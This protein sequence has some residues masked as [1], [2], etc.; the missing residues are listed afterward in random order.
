MGRDHQVGR[1]ELRAPLAAAVLGGVISSTA[2]TL[3]LIPVVYS[4]LESVPGLVGRIMRFT[5]LAALRSQRS[6]PAAGDSS[7][8][9]GG[10]S[11]G[12]A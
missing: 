3:I 11:G 8:G 1:T 9:S 10:G 2:L 12:G 5:G 6:V 7:G 4:L